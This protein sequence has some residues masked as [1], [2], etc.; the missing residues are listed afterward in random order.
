MDA[1]MRKDLPIRTIVVYPSWI[2]GV[3]EGEVTASV[4]I[5]GS[6]GSGRADVVARVNTSTE[7]V[8]RENFRLTSRYT[9]PAKSTVGV[10]MFYDMFE[11]AGAAGTWGPGANRVRL[12][13]IQHTFA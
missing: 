7:L 5:V 3:G 4:C 8:M 10:R 12:S 11:K 6:L 9:G 1:G 2:Y 13:V